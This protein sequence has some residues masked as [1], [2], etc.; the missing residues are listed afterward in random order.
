MKEEDK[1]RMIEIILKKG[2]VDNSLFLYNSKERDEFLSRYGLKELADKI[3]RLDNDYMYSEDVGAMRNIED[4][5]KAA[6][7]D[8]AGQCKKILEENGVNVDKMFGEG[9]NAEQE[10]E[11]V[12]KQL[13]Q[14]GI[15][16]EL[17]GQLGLDDISFLKSDGKEC[18]FELDDNTSNR[19]ALERNEVEYTRSKGKLRI[20]GRFEVKEG[21]SYDD[22]SE[23]RRILDREEI[24]YIKFAQ[25]EKIGNGRKEK[26]FVP[27]NW[28]NGLFPVTNSQLVKN[29]EKLAIIGASSL[30]LSPAGAVLLL[31]V[32]QR[33]GLYRNM[34]KQKELNKGERIALEKGLTVFKQNEKNARYYY[35]DKGN[36][37]SINARDVR[38][39]SVVN[40]VHMSPAEMERVRRGELVMLKGKDGEEFGIRID[41]T[42]RN[43]LQE[44]YREMKSD[45]EMKAVPNPISPDQDKLDYIAK[46]GFS[47]IIDIYG[48]KNLNLE[49]DSFISRYGIKTAY[50]DIKGMEERMRN[51][52]PGQKG[53]LEN[54]IRKEDARLKETAAA[55][56]ITLAKDNKKGVAL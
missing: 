26:L 4:N 10:K 54:E 46:K 1:Q 39:P 36:I 49:R 23:N 34:L 24:N 52:S 44:Y 13:E 8:M 3:D 17:A 40:G 38:I 31:L 45:R 12:M 48:R 2:N 50:T 27:V 7:A 30:I 16:P 22:T 18:W 11:E 15:T 51:V 47:G 56:S 25:G 20:N 19:K 41:V 55:E 28:R 6:Q 35:M 29:M 42:K 53:T 32:L 33:T 9:L 14:Y 43:G 5:K 37:C 21:I